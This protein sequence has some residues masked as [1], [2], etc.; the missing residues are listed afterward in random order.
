[1]FNKHDSLETAN[2]SKI[3]LTKLS[4]NCLCLRNI[5]K[6]LSFE[7]KSKIFYKPSEKQIYKSMQ[8]SEKILIYTKTV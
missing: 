4:P 6:L 3:Q 8:T 2:K 7:K 1:M 5:L